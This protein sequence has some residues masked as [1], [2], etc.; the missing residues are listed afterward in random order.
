M[1]EDINEHL[2]RKRNLGPPQ[3]ESKEEGETCGKK[4][5]CK[6]NLVVV[7]R[8][9]KDLLELLPNRKAERR[10]AIEPVLGPDPKPGDTQKFVFPGDEKKIEAFSEG[11]ANQGRSDGPHTD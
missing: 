6:P 11:P 3:I 5:G 8:M 10:R 9:E 2:K 4:R 1:G 7:E